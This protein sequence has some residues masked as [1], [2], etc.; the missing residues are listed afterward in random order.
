[1]V[2]DQWPTPIIF[3]GFEIGYAILTGQRLYESTGE[4]NPVR[5]CYELYMNAI[6]SPTKDRYSWDQTAVVVGVRGPQDHWDVVE[7][8]NSVNEG[9]GSNTWIQTETTTTTTGGQQQRHGYL[10]VR[11]APATVAKHIEDLM[12]EATPPPAETGRK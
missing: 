7:G 3:S 5:K 12:I 6:E 8:V 2:V 4:D 1:M 10:V 9:D 11:E